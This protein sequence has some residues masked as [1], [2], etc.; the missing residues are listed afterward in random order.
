MHVPFIHRRSTDGGASGGTGSAG[1]SGTAGGAAGTAASGAGTGAAAGAGAT[2]ASAGGISG[3]SGA[4]SPSPAASSAGQGAAAPSNAASGDW[5]S[6]FNDDI[7]GY[8]QNKGWKGPDGLI[9]SYRGMEKLLGAGPENLIKIP[10]GDNAAEVHTA[11]SKLGKPEK[12]DMYNL[13][14]P[15]EGAAD[16][17]FMAWAKNAFHNSNLTAKQAE[18]LVTQWNDFQGTTSKAQQELVAA[19]VADEGKALRREWGAA[20]DQNAAMAENAAKTFGVKPEVVEA[21]KSK[22]GHSEVIK[23]FHTIAQGLGED[24]FVNGTGAKGSFVN[25]PEQAKSK[26]GELMKDQ[27]WS[28]KYLAGDRAAREEFDTLSKHAFPEE[29]TG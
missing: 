14:A 21:L 5:T 25:T 6:G 9:E 3:Q 15:K 11:F 22:M 18:Q 7:K 23:M 13:P 16:K 26:I 20:Y 27:A 29:A 2:G 24:R 10:A 28:A 4:A 8:V 17:D 1:A 12:A 19:K